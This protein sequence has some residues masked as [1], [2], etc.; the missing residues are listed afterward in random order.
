[1]SKSFYS[2]R[3]GGVKLVCKYTTTS[4]GKP[5]LA[6][7]KSLT[8][9]LKPRKFLSVLQTQ[10]LNYIKTVD[11]FATSNECCYKYGAPCCLLTEKLC[12]N[13]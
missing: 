7:L 3:S 8:S 13:T 1:M 2:W 12:N 11:L 6:K 10:P 5:F 4:S 9:E